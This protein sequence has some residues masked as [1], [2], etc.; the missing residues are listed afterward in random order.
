MHWDAD[1][2]AWVDSW[3]GV[4]SETEYLDHL[5]WLTWEI[6][7][8]YWTYIIDGDHSYYIDEWGLAYSEREYEIYMNVFTHW[9][10]SVWEYSSYDYL[11]YD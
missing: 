6:E 7:S 8:A 1:A 5:M 10:P 4:H 3:G 2:E 9:E 11:W